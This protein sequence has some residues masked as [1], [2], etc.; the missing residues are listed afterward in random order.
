MNNF[1]IIYVCYNCDNKYKNIA[2]N[3]LNE[4]KYIIN[5]IYDFDYNITDNILKFIYDIK[6]CKKCKLSYVSPI[7]TT[8]KS[9]KTLKTNY[10]KIKN[11]CLKYV[12]MFILF[13][14]ILLLLYSFFILIYIFITNVIYRNKKYK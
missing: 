9:D 14:Y 1:I 3:I 5:K 4:K 7:Y 12:K 8:I 11:K 10:I 13:I 6:F 2:N